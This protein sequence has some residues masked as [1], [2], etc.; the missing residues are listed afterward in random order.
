[1][2]KILLASGLMFVAAF[3]AQAQGV[4]NFSS[5]GAGVAARFATAS[6][7]PGGSNLVSSSMSTIR[8]DLFWT[9]GTT[10]VGVNVDSLAGAGF[11]QI[12]SSVAAQAGYFSGG[13]K[14]ITGAT[15]GNS[16]VA[17]V[18]V[19]DTAFG[20]YDAARQAGGQFFAS[21]LFLITPALVPPNTPPNLVGLGTGGVV[22]QLQIVPEP[23]SMALAGLGA[24]SLLLFRRR[25]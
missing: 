1:M 10:T 5:A 12:F 13:S 6:G 22:Y 7:S 14:T 11:N 9:A 24:A 2:K 25:K 18:R 4:I 17:Q 16:I 15:P 19:W 3:A 20:S 8:A 21:Q 23:S